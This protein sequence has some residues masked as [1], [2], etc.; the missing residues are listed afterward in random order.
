MESGLHQC[1]AT[2]TLYYCFCGLEVIVLLNDIYFHNPNTL[3]V[4]PKLSVD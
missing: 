3:L 2:R 4:Q 1:I